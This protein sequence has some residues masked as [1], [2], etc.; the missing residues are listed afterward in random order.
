MLLECQTW[1][2]SWDPGLR[3]IQ[4]IVVKVY[5]YRSK[6]SILLHEIFA[7]KNIFFPSATRPMWWTVQ[8]GGH[9]SVN[10]QT[11]IKVHCCKETSNKEN[12]SLD[13]TRIL[14]SVLA[15]ISSE[16]LC[17]GSRITAGGQGAACSPGMHASPEA[18]WYNHPSTAV[19]WG[20]KWKVLYPARKT[21]LGNYLHWN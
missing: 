12:P 20:R 9:I 17:R 7:L 21:L 2:G 4:G 18:T 13:Y 19:M 1:A 8:S 6:L 5:E 3:G 10:E 11:L 16:L 15:L 14:H